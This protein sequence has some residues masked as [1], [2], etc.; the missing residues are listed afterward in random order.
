MK[1]RLLPFLLSAMLVCAAACSDD[2]TTGG[3]GGVGMTVKVNGAALNITSLSHGYNT[4][5]FFANGKTTLFPPNQTV[6]IT[7]D[8]IYGT[9]NF[10][11][12]GPGSIA[13]GEYET[14]DASSNRVTYTTDGNVQRGM[15]VVTEY[16]ATTEHFKGTFFFTAINKTN[17]NDSVVVTEGTFDV[18]KP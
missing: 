2:P 4:K 8:S 17:P 9:G 16:N 15:I 3:G 5:A 6:D 11:L 12:G 1:T 7:I 18:T 14:A 10:P 13:T